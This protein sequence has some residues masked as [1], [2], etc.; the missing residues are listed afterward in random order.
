MII[1]GFAYWRR[2]NVTSRHQ[3]GWDLSDHGSEDWE[4]ESLRACCNHQV[5]PIRVALLVFLG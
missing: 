3:M 4:F 5:Q 2:R 1:L